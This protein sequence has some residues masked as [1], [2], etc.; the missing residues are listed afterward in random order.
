MPDRDHAVAVT[1]PGN[2]EWRT[3]TAS[4]TLYEN[5]MPRST[6]RASRFDGRTRPDRDE[7][8]RPLGRGSAPS[9]NTTTGSRSPGKSSSKAEPGLFYIQAIPGRFRFEYNMTVDLRLEKTIASKRARCASSSTV[10]TS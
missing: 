5:P 6:P 9:P 10:S 4:R 7:L 1:N 3:T 2:T 8:P